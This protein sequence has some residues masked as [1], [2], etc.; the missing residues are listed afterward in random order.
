MVRR[1]AS[2]YFA[3]AVAALV[4]SLLVWV[5]ARADLLALLGVSWESRLTWNWLEPRLL[6]GSFWALGLP[7]VRRRLQSVTRAA[8]VLS[9]APAL[10][11]LFYLL[12]ESGHGMLGVGY[13]AL[14]PV[15]VLGTNACWGWIVSLVVVR[16]E[17]AG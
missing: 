5:V 9:L 10:F 3:G 16:A 13:G 4:T 11:E 12:P 15:F 8:L 17:G 2:A 7:A 14:T 1:L 6:W